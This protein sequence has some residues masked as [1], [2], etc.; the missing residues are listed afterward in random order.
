MFDDKRGPYLVQLFPHDTVILCGDLNR[1]DTTLLSADLGLTQLV[2]EPTRG[3]NVLDKFFVNRDD[4]YT[5]SVVKPCVK[6]GCCRLRCRRDSYWGR[7]AKQTAS[8]NLI[9]YPRTAFSETAGSLRA[10]QLDT[11]LYRSGYKFRILCLT[12]S[13]KMAHKRIYSDKTC[14]TRISAVIVCYTSR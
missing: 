1:L 11:R 10:L 8:I 6:T 13:V 14:L 2:D 3:R 9:R 12:R 4:I 7:K 5:V